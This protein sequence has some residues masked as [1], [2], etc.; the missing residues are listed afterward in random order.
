MATAT[1][2]RTIV[3]PFGVEIDTKRN[4]DVLLAAI[5]NCRLRTAIRADKTVT[6]FKRIPPE[7]MTPI[8]QV[9]NIGQLP[10]TPGMQIHVNPEK[11]KYEIIDPLFGDEELCEKLRVRLDI[12][13]GFR[14]SDKLS[15]VPPKK[16]SLDVHRMKNLCR[17]LIW[18]MDEG[19]AKMVKGVKPEIEDVNDLPG[20]YLKNPGSKIR[21]GQPTFEKDFDAWYERLTLVGG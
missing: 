13:S 6:D 2:E 20:N 17:E 1:K 5:P 18:I 12:N 8:D 7:E 19:N 10:R 15:G 21:S 14:I 11:C 16:G 9:R 3:A 4:S